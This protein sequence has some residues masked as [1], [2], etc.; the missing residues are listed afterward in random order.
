M[1]YALAKA[2]EAGFDVFNA[3]DIMDNVNFLDELKFGVGDGYLHYYFYNYNLISRLTPS[4]IG[5]ILV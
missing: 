1:K 5:I 3:L 2:K 4:Q